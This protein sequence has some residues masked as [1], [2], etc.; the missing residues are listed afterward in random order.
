MGKLNNKCAKCKRKYK[1][2]RNYNRHIKQCGQEAKYTC[3]CG[4][5]FKRSDYLKDHKRRCKGA[6]EPAA[7]AVVNAFES[8]GDE[9]EQ[10]E[11]WY[12]Q[13]CEVSVS[14]TEKM[15]H[16][17]SAEHK[18]RA[19]IEK[20]DNTYL[21]DDCFEGKVVTYRLINIDLEN[22]SMR[23][24][25]DGKKAA[26]SSLLNKYVEEHQAAN[27]QLE[28]AATY[29]KDD[30]DGGTIKST[31]YIVNKYMD[32]NLSDTVR[33]EALEKKLSDAFDQLCAN[34]EEVTNK[35]SNWTLSAIQHLELRMNEKVSL[36]GGGEFI[37]L[38]E[39]IV[40]KKACI[41]PVKNDQQ[42]FKWCINAYFLYQLRAVEFK[43]TL[44]EL[45]KNKVLTST[46]RLNR[47]QNEYHKLNR[48]LS[49]IST[50]DEALVDESFNISFEG[51]KY[52]VELDTLEDFT[53]QNL[54]IN[55]NVF[56]LSAEDNKTIVGPLFASRRK[57]K[58]NINLLYLTEGNKS[59]YV[60]IKDLSRL[61]SRQKKNRRDKHYYCEVCL[62]AFNSEGKLKEHQEHD[63]LGKFI[64][65][66]LIC[67]FL[68]PIIFSF[69]LILVLCR[70][71]HRLA[72]TW[73]NAKV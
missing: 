51:V 61:A 54:D 31:F 35:G 70:N 9:E 42:C 4:G 66:F 41:N 38:P 71:S 26:M 18:E 13:H 39:F 62:L 14:E 64:S 65:T 2:K 16:C 57:A 29:C 40:N 22:V 23:E 72:S 59:H 6:P 27:F 45:K 52:P 47:I 53:A 5:K 49:N 19:L 28:V 58:Y 37:E 10:K 48:Q 21:V 12:C 69:L 17:Q 46:A 11:D 7:E 73:S 25:L 67:L 55:L 43:N 56:G 15:K 33:A 36:I 32:V 8:G 20:D 1:H 44:E 34:A 63:C 50:S 24:F 60:W 68:F 30:L 3:I